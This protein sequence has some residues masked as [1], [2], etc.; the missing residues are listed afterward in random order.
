MHFS[1]SS[2]AHA[3]D[4]VIEHHFVKNSLR[5]EII[6]NSNGIE[7][8][9]KAL[10]LI[11]E[12]KAVE[13]Y[14]INND[15]KQIF[16]LKYSAV[17]VFDSFK[18]YQKFEDRI[19]PIFSGAKE[20]NFL[21][22][23]EDLTTDLIERNMPTDKYQLRTYLIAEFNEITLK[24]TTLF[25]P[26]QCHKQQLIEVNR[27]STLTMKW[28]KDLYFIA[29]IRN[30]HGCTLTFGLFANGYPAS[31][32]LLFESGKLFPSG[33]V[34]ELYATLRKRLNY[35]YILKPISVE[36]REYRIAESDLA[37]AI[38][39]F[40]QNNFKQLFLSAPLYSSSL[41]IAVPPGQ[42]YT[43]I[44]KLFLPFDKTTWIFFLLLFGIAFGVIVIM[45]VSKS[46]SFISFVA[47]ENVA[48]P[49]LNVFAAYMG[50][51]QLTL[52]LRNVARFLLMN[53]VLYSLVMRTLYQSKV[54]EQLVA[55][56]DKPGV[57]TIDELVDKN[58][59][60][61]IERYEHELET[62]YYKDLDIVKRWELNK[63]STQTD[64]NYIIE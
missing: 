22:Y 50:I 14:R 62:S 46:P 64:Y 35:N 49:G 58:F 59:S 3:I 48:N 36:E 37:L 10:R 4:N 8:L 60:L 57:E 38:F 5:F 7:E 19:E 44:E 23:C 43:A 51:G 41:V 40:D 30:F 32:Y 63:N 16:Q 33:F 15:D 18:N 24:S 25:T 9:E 61:Y 31:G 28:E 11:R 52:P 20:V 39:G 21:I 26:Q 29:K 56:E 53:L 2:I 55:D 13:L 1:N 54:V 47:G 42:P 34:P 27:F 45:R 17:L 6:F 12:K